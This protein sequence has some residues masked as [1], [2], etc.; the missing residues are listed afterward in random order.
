MLVQFQ[1]WEARDQQRAHQQ[2][3]LRISPQKPDQLS[4]VR[5]AAISQELPVVNEETVASAIVFT[6]GMRDPYRE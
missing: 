6:K 1:V 2:I 5:T 3:T 4:W